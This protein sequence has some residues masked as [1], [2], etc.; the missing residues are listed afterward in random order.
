M[1]DWK[2]A[3]FALQALTVLVTV[4]SFFVFKFNDMRHLGEDITKINTSIKEI[5]KNIVK[6]TNAQIKRDAVCDTRHNKN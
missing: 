4:T 2:I 1:F 5:N 6:I 3:I